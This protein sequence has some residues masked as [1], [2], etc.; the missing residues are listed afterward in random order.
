MSYSH[1]PGTNGPTA[2]AAQFGAERKKQEYFS[3]QSGMTM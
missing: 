3:P 1:S 2:P